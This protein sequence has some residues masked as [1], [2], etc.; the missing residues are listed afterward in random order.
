MVDSFPDEV[1]FGVLGEKKPR[2]FG[3]GIPDPSPTSLN[4]N[5]MSLGVFSLRD[6]WTHLSCLPFKGRDSSHPG[7]L[8]PLRMPPPF[9]RLCHNVAS[10]AH[11]LLSPKG[12]CVAGDRDNLDSSH[13]NTKLTSHHSHARLQL[14]L[15]GPADIQTSA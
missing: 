8:C 6:P 14:L 4:L 13:E 10:R 3:P 9:L 12:C 7:S 5:P 1:L 11:P 15:F 2:D